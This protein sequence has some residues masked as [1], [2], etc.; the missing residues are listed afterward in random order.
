MRKHNYFQEDTFYKNRNI[1]DSGMSDIVKTRRTSYDVV[2]FIIENHDYET[3]W[4]PS[5]TAD[6][7]SCID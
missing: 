3:T 2:S 6:E 1:I 7:S 5:S 4:L